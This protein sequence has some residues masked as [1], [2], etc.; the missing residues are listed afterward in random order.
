LQISLLL[1]GH[2]PGKE[3]ISVWFIMMYKWKPTTPTKY[4]IQ[5]KALSL[6]SWLKY[7]QL[8]TNGK[9]INVLN[10]D[11]KIFW[12]QQT[13]WLLLKGIMS[14][15]TCRLCKVPVHSRYD[16][17]WLC[18]GLWQSPIKC[19]VIMWETVQCPLCIK[20]LHI[21][22]NCSIYIFRWLN[23]Y[24]YNKT[25]IHHSHTPHFQEYS[26]VLLVLKNRPHTQCSFKVDVSFFIIVL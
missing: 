2:E 8:Q 12:Y 22:W 15:F 17:A 1:K 19:S 24:S 11:W 10:N 16:P 4:Y 20:I 14:V 7:N 23:G 6:N 5:F 9:K 3:E 21:L 18:K 26:A 25:A 13:S